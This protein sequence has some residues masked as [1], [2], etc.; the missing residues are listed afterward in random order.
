MRSVVSNNLNPARFS[1]AMLLKKPTS[2][3]PIPMRR[4]NAHFREIY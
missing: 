2:P 1:T 4:A 3:V